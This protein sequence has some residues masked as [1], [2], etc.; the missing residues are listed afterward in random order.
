LLL[1]LLAV[2]PVASS[3]P[4]TADMSVS[5]P[6]TYKLRYHFLD[7]KLFMWRN[8]LSI[9]P[10]INKSLY[11]LALLL[12]SFYFQPKLFTSFE[13]FCSYFWNFGLIPAEE[14]MMIYLEVERKIYTGRIYMDG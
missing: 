13:I 11:L 2:L 7:V 8:I 9:K 14:D 5:W 6:K 10:F 4:K 3:F 1:L 12:T